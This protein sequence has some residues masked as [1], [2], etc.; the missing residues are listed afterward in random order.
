MLEYVHFTNRVKYNKIFGDISK[1]SSEEEARAIFT[2][3]NNL[4]YCSAGHLMHENTM[5]GKTVLAVTGA[6]EA[7]MALGWM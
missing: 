3:E 7:W 2:N 6:S 4:M 5:F 1:T